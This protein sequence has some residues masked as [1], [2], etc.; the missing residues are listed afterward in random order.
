ML[1]INS[2][3]ILKK[4]FLVNNNLWNTSNTFEILI[5]IGNLE[6]FYS[7]NIVNKIIEIIPSI[8][9]HNCSKDNNFITN[10]KKDNS[11]VHIIQYI[12]IELLLY[13]TNWK[14]SGYIKN[15]DKKDIYYIIIECDT[16][17]ENIV[18]EC[19]NYTLELLFDILNNNASLFKIKN[20]IIELFN[21][22]KK[23]KFTTI[24]L[25]YL[26][27]YNIPYIYIEKHNYLQ[28]GY[29]KN[30]IRFINNDFPNCN[31]VAKSV[32]NDIDLYKSILEDNNIP[33]IKSN[34]VNNYEDC[35]KIY[36][37][38]DAPIIIKP[39]YKKIK[40][41]FIINYNLNSLL[42]NWISTYKKNY[43]ESKKVIIEK[44]NN[45]TFYKSIIINKKI[46]C[47][48]KIDYIEKDIELIGNNKHTII[49]LYNEYISKEYLTN[50]KMCK[51][52]Y[53]NN[54]IYS[55]YD[56]FNNYINKINININNIPT[57]NEKILLK[58]KYINPIE[59]NNIND[60]FINKLN[61]CI[62]ILDLD[63][64]EITFIINDLNNLVIN[65]SNFAI[66]KIKLDIDF[67]LAESCKNK[68]NNIIENIID[69]N[70]NYFIPIIGLVSNNDN[71]II[72]SIITNFF[73]SLN[74]YIINCNNH[75]YIINNKN[76]KT[77]NTYKWENKELAI[78][79]N[80]T[81]VIIFDIKTNDIINEGIYYK[82]YVSVIIDNINNDNINLLKKII[83]NNNDFVILNAND[84]NIEKI[85]NNTNRIIFYTN[86]HYKNTNPYISN[87]YKNSKWVYIYDNV[88]NIMYNDNIYEIYNIKNNL[89]VDKILIS[90]AS[91]WSVI[92]ITNLDIKN[93]LII[94]LFNIN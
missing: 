38:I 32:C 88:I 70:K 44:Y 56:Y 85:L 49:E 79:N 64:C 75:N 10:I 27:N 22:N 25:K 35:I 80:N 20:K 28:I 18:S 76:I 23:N 5:D 16:L 4:T 34:I 74:M 46:I 73:I 15:T 33:T 61:Q 30:Q 65:R 59:I 71:S 17:N 72:N 53:E 66:S 67:C 86:K 89:N 93:K 31:G 55:D 29:G 81:D 3:K 36:N 84:I 52:Y 42:N 58:K 1:N 45:G 6:N 9:Y 62:N 60:I 83:E 21:F 82:K 69:V 57:I 37:L 91:I 54:D 68:F 51:K 87:K 43:I 13:T 41:G 14:P 77:N 11:I 48:Y 50:L 26:N 78:I 39:Y 12:M 47:I 63:T 7:E 8:Q 24:F 40:C 92:D 94:Y 19:L 2:I 90:I